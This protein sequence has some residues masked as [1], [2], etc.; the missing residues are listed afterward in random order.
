MAPGCPACPTS[1]HRP[2]CCEAL[3]TSAG[4]CGCRA[5]SLMVPD[6]VSHD[7]GT[8]YNT[9]PAMWAKVDW[10]LDDMCNT[11]YPG[12]HAATMLEL[13][14]G[15]TGLPANNSIWN[16]SAWL[17]SKLWIVPGCKGAHE[18][19]WAPPTPD[20]VIRHGRPEV[21]TRL[22]HPIR[23]QQGRQRHAAAQPAALPS[24]YTASQAARKP[25]SQPP[26]QTRQST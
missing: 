3:P 21:A 19:T 6:S 9:T 17:P 14:T 8:H 1:S 5:E 4:S 10:P 12:S 25:G 2:R 26:R 11:Q 15:V 13:T 18:G 22:G 7:N 20:I 23:S 16:G 24:R